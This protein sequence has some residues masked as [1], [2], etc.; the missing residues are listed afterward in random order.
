MPSALLGAEVGIFATVSMTL[1]VG[2]DIQAS[3]SLSGSI[4][5]Y[6][7]LSPQS[8]AD[9]VWEALS[10]DHNTPGTM[11]EKLNGAGSAGNPWS[12]V[13]DGKTAAQLMAI[14]AAAL[15]GKTSGQPGSPVFR[16]ID[17]STNRI[18]A[19]VDANGNRTSVTVTP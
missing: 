13:I 10:A 1:T 11:G 12:E 7:E 18:V 16:A 19:T 15:A 4:L 8:L 17:D 3:G 2:G 14:M 5:P 6:T 9:A